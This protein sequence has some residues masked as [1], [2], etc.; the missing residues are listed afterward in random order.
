MMFKYNRAKKN[1]AVLTVRRMPSRIAC[2]LVAALA[3]GAVQGQAQLP[4]AHTADAA[5][6]AAPV[7][8][9]TKQEGD[10]FVYVTR[11]NAGVVRRLLEQG[12]NPNVRDEN[13][14]TPMTLALQ[15]GSLNA[16]DALMASAKTNV[17]YRN[18]NDESPLMLA[19]IRGHLDAVTRLIRQ[20]AHVNK[21][22]WSPLHY[23]ASGGGEQQLEIARLLLAKDA[24]IDPRSPNDTTPLMMA[25]QYGSDGM[26]K[27]LLAEG[28]DPT[29]QN[30]LGLTAADFAS[31]SGRDTLAQQ[32]NA[33]AVQLQ[34]Q[35]SQPRKAAPSP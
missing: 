17:E 3:C 34:Q 32:L 21:T 4:N 23:A 30:Q 25:A 2:V 28:A 9:L 11:D 20:G 16:F 6:Y 27:L 26:V 1:G 13:G 35:R 7:K 5:A 19:A 15:L 24:Y 8:P 12:A 29:M 10:L 14:Q 22:L 31:R 18:S 33:S